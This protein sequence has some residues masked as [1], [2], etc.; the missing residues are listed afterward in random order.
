MQIII[1]PY[2][3]KILIIIGIVVTLG[4]VFLA[5]YPSLFNSNVSQTAKISPDEKSAVDAVTVFYT[6]DYTED[7][8]LWVARI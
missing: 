3:K 2:V 6:L 4:I 7:P 8:N 1:P 5:I